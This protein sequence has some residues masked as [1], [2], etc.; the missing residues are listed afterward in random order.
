MRLLLFVL[1]VMALITSNWYWYEAGK[2]SVDPI[3][4]MCQETELVL[5][6]SRISKDEVVCVYIESWQIKGKVK[7]TENV[8]Q[9]KT[10]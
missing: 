5:V 2:A 9:K 4:P 6:A 8:F 10:S 3:V 1:F 7:R